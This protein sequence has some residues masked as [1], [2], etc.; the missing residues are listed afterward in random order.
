MLLSKI[1]NYEKQLEDAAI[2]RK[3]NHQ[4]NMD[5]FEELKQ[6]I[7]LLQPPNA[8]SASD[9]NDSLSPTTDP[10]HLC[11]GIESLPERLDRCG[12]SENENAC[13]SNDGC[14]WNANK[15]RCFPDIQEPVKNMICKFPDYSILNICEDTLYFVSPRHAL[16]KK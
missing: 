11:D 2:A 6:Y 8:H 16:G 4:L 5:K 10:I 3:E 14:M 13:M 1:S 7:C 9:S 12:Q 15:T